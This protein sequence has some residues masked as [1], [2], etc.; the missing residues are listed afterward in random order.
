MMVSQITYNALAGA[1]WF[2]EP[3]TSTTLSGGAMVLGAVLWLSAMG[4]KR[5]TAS[6]ARSEGE[7]GN[8]DFK[9][10]RA[11]SVR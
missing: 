3:L 10:R 9:A 11:M 2:G 5:R 7:V 6:F 4:L 8:Q 1:L